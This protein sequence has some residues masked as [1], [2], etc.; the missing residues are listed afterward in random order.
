[1]SLVDLV[2]INFFR[3]YKVVGPIIFFS[4]LLMVWGGLWLVV[5]IFLRVAIIVRGC[6]VW[7]LTAFWGTLFQLQLERWHDGGR[8]PMSGGDAGQRGHTCACWRRGQGAEFGG[9]PQEVSVVARRTRRGRSKRP[10]PRIQ[11]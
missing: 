11:C 3:L 6:G 10:C 5:T 8:G 9:S 1:M 7:V 4:L 2:G